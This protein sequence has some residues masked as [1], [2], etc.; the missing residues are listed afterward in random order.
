M[1]KLLL[2]F[3]MSIY[4]LPIVSLSQTLYS[5]QSSFDIAEVTKTENSFDF[6]K[7]TIYTESLGA[8]GLGVSINY[9]RAFPIDKKSSINLSGGL[10]IIFTSWND[11]SE[12]VLPFS[13]TIVAGEKHALEIGFGYSHLVFEKMK[14]PNFIIG[15]RLQQ[16]RFFFWCG[17]VNLLFIDEHGDRETEWPF[18][19]VPGFRF[20]TSF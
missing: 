15:Y 5:K 2:T 9:K 8:T 3:L 1:K 13:L 6:Y 10:G 17:L 16:S 19:P 4:I 12:M 14:A 20:G 18:L 11:E 7:N